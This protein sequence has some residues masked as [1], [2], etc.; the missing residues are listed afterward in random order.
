MFKESQT[1]SWPPRPFVPKLLLLMFG[2]VIIEYC[3]LYGFI[4]TSYFD[5]LLD[6][7]ANAL[8][9]TSMSKLEFE[10][11]SDATKTNLAWLVLAQTQVSDGSRVRVWLSSSDEL[12]L[13]QVLTIIGRF[14]SN[15]SSDW[16]VSN[17]ARGIAG[18]VKVVRLITSQDTSSPWKLLISLRQHLLVYIDAEANAERALL[19][20]VIC[21]YRTSAKTF[22]VE[23]SYS[24]AG[25]S[26]LIAVSGSHLAVVASCYESIFM[27]FDV[28]PRRRYAFCVGITGLYVVFCASPLSAIRSW[29]MYVLSRGGFLFN[30]RSSSLSALGL[31]GIL[32]C[33]LD[34]YC[35]ADLGFQLSVLSVCALSLFSDYMGALLGSLHAPDGVS[36]FA[37]A[38]PYGIQNR[39][40]SMLLAA[41]NCLSASLVCQLATFC[42]CAV[43]FGTI[44]VVAPLA[45]VVIAPLFGPIVMLGLCA[46]SLSFIPFLGSLALQIPLALCFCANTAARLLASIPFASL[47]VEADKA[48]LLVPF[49]MGFVVYIAWPRPSQVQILSFTS[50]VLLSTLFW[51]LC[52]TVFVPPQVVMLDV[53]QGDALLI[54]DGLS[55][56][57]VDTGPSGA[58]SEALARNNVFRLDAVVLTH[59][60]DDHIGGL[61]DLETSCAV[62]KVFV[63]M[64]VA[65]NLSTSV[66][67]EINSL[68]SSEVEE[69]N[70][71]DRA[72]V[73]SF[74]LTCLWPDEE[75]DGSENADSLCFLLTHNDNFK[76]LFSGDAEQDVLREITPQVG[77]IDVLK[78]GHHGSEISIDEQEAL[79][80][81]PE[82]A[83]V[84]AGANNSYGHPTR[85]CKDILEDAGALFMCTIDYG[86][87]AVMPVQEG[88]KV[89]SERTVE[90][91]V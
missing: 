80:L 62:S 4:K 22:G 38:I 45:N 21:G 8:R 36:V 83:I 35:V 23:E 30:R 63:G 16:G 42:C 19:A 5:E 6:A 81:K 49:V 46:C 77:D 51:V 55:C 39:V 28:E 56:V 69:L 3:I 59:L 10:V 7:P 43:T 68:T 58:L 1:A 57:L 14:T 75:R 88:L 12:K 48:F 65:D 76:M 72:K 89:R 74:T 82:L 15:D 31:A 70:V 86:D 84:S 87:I 25:L 60:H 24:R 13:G 78:V 40:N 33:M 71:G 37:R 9:K 64:G 32:M 53:G 85:E 18:R 54:R 44:S 41:K 73:G 67:D 20:G 90:P 29:I 66:K 91:D 34:P 17:R 50:I 27:F 79:S 2:F 52:I 61:K 47:V 26:H 11:I